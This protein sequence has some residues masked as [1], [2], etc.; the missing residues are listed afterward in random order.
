[1]AINKRL[2]AVQSIRQKL[3]G[4][5]AALASL[6]CLKQAMIEVPGA[7]SA[8]EAHWSRASAIWCGNEAAPSTL[9]QGMLEAQ[10]VLDGLANALKE[11]IEAW[12][13]EDLGNGKI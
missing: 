12:E 7:G 1:M 13:C 3:D 10:D 9:E 2:R 6:A 5:N 4:I 8:A 11:D